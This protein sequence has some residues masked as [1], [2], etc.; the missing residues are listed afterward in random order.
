MWK[1]ID[2]APVDELVLLFCPRRHFT[3]CERIEIGAARTSTGSHHAWATHWAYLPT[4]P[5]QNEIERILADEQE[6]EY[7]E[8]MAEEEYQQEMQRTHG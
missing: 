6:R 4:G 7:H 8:R 1:P 5:D 2:T 3:N